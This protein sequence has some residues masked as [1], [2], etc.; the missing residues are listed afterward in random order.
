MAIRKDFCLIGYNEV[1][2]RGSSYFSTLTFTDESNSGS[3]LASAPLSNLNDR[4]RATVWCRR[5]FSPPASGSIGTSYARIRINLVPN[6]LLQA[7]YPAAGIIGIMN[8]MCVDS[9]GYPYSC[10]VQ[11]Q[12]SSDGFATT[13]FDESRIVDPASHLPNDVW[14]PFEHMTGIY[15]ADDQLRLGGEVW[16]ARG[17]VPL[18]GYGLN[19]ELRVTIVPCVAPPA[20]SGNLNITVGR[21]GI[22]KAVKAKVGPTLQ[23][24]SRDTSSIQYAKSGNGPFV[25]RFMTART[26]RASL[27][28]RATNI[29]GRTGYYTG[30]TASRE[31]SQEF[32]DASLTGSAS[33]YFATIMGINYDAG[34]NGDVVFIPSVDFPT[35]YYTSSSFAT[36]TGAA[37][38]RSHIAWQAMPVHGL[39]DREISYGMVARKKSTDR[40]VWQGQ[41]VL[42]EHPPIRNTVIG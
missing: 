23:Y 2:S 30:T 17:G 10:R 7:T 11:L 40:Q 41:M 5:A 9:N 19:F 20:V 27:I 36:L 16:T 18:T 24:G 8:V 32:V 3:T 21:V 34:A 37:S 26:C 33:G 15:A 22:F 28:L 42:N 38:A 1:L 29:F 14:F 4:D 13:F 12:A 25:D 35:G 31:W 6:A 39:I